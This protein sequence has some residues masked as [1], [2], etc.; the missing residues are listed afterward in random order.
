M[1]SQEGGVSAENRLLMIIK[2][3]LFIHEC[4]GGKVLYVLTAWNIE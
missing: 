1:C 4:I 2:L 3:L